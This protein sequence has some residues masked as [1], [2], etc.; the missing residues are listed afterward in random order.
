MT[1]QKQ[2]N[3]RHRILLITAITLAFAY[4][5]TLSSAD[6]EKPV[7]HASAARSA[8][9]ISR[10]CAVEVG[11]NPDEKGRKITAEEMK[12][13]TACADRHLKQ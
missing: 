1:K 3:I 7:D 11:I 13:M 9:T 6:T 10:R 5:Y 12:V 4:F 2:V 8:E